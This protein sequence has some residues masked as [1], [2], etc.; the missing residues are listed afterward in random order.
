MKQLPLT[1]RFIVALVAVALFLGGWAW[2]D[3]YQYGKF[4]LYENTDDFFKFEHPND[5]EIEQYVSNVERLYREDTYGG[6]TPQETFDMFRNA[7]KAGDIELAAKY[8]VPELQASKLTYLNQVVKFGLMEEF[9]SYLDRAKSDGE[10]PKMGSYFFYTV[11]EN[12]MMELDFQLF[13]NEQAKIWK[14]QSL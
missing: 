11:D 14:M 12:N 6:K 3:E 7:L 9:I 13:F 8:F 5:K 1:D 10:E 2:Y 4:V